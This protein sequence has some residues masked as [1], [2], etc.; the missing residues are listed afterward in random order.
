MESKKVIKKQSTLK[1]DL[2]EIKIVIEIMKKQIAQLEDK[3]GLATKKTPLYTEEDL[4]EMAQ[5]KKKV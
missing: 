3:L 2:A 1:E 5:M 4:R